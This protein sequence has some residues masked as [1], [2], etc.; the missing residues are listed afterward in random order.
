MKKIGTSIA[1][2][3]LY[4]FAAAQQPYPAAPAAAGN[5]T[6]IEYFVDAIPAFGAGTPLTGF[7]AATDVNAFA[8]TVNITGLTPGFHRI[9]FR[10]RNINGIWSLTSNSFFDNYTVPVYPTA[11]PAPTNINNIEYFIDANPAFGSGI[12]ITGF[13]PSIDI[14]GFAASINLTGVTPGYHNIYVRSKNANQQW[15]LTNLGVFDNSISLP[16]PAAAAPVTNIVQL[17]YFI[18]NNDLGFG[19]CTPISFTPGT[20]IFNLNANIN[21]T[22][23]PAGVHR[24]YIRGRDANGNWSLTNVDVFDNA[25]AIPYPSA[26]SPTTNLV[27]LEYFIDNNDLGFGNCTQIPFTA[28]TNI[29]NLN[30]NINISG[31]PTGV[32]IAYIRGKDANGKWSLTNFSVFDNSATTPYPSAPAAAPAIGNMEYFVDVDPGFGNATPIT[33]PVNTG[34]VNNYAVNIAL[35]GSLSAGTHY[36]YIRSKQNPWSLTNVVPFDALGT[37][38]VTWA[39]IKAQLL[40]NN[41]LVSWATLRESNS[42]H[43][44]IEHSTNGSNFT[45][46]GELTAAGNSNTTKHYSYTHIN[47]A[48]GFN[49][50]RIKQIDNDGQFKY[51]IIVTVLKSNTQQQTVIAPNPVKE[52]LHIAEPEL[53]FVQ[54]AEIYSTDGALLIRKNIQTDVQVFSIPVIKLAAGSYIIKVNYK[55]DSKSFR[56]IKD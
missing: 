24:V 19:N 54:S 4:I 50:Y 20:N 16:Y 47:P 39:F 23:L 53:K 45:K 28:G 55:N 8:G 34:D 15:S 29:T 42:S 43:F 33:V 18:D 13:T 27:Q 25:S 30:T 41:T 35:S 31:L 17:E 38:P 11:Q 26:P 51:S 32:H 10:A 49:F 37:V 6:A 2:S 22:G 14:N 1:I 52:L 36:L 5:I 46:L 48:S 56:F 3:L 40:N 12:A 9:Y 7:T 44:N 21:I